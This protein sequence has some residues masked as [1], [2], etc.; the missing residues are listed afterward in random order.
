MKAEESFFSIELVLSFVHFELST[1][2]CPTNL[3]QNYG[4]RI[5]CNHGGQKLKRGDDTKAKYKS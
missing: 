2:S 5:V 4:K 1:N 3:E